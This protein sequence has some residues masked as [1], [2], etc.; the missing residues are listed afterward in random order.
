MP[1]SFIV[2]H[3]RPPFLITTDRSL[4]DLDVV[5]D[6]LFTCYWCSGIPREIVARS[7]D[8]SLCFSIFEEVGEGKRAQVGFARVISDFATYAYLAD[9]FVLESHRGKGLSK[10]MMECIMAHP[11]FLGLRRSGSIDSFDYHEFYDRESVPSYINS[12]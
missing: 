2:T 4:I 6:F 8:G 5:H 3:R 11:Q 12:I 9:V 7:I 10:W 1:D